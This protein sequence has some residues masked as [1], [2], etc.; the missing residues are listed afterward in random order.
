MKDAVS[1]DDF[2]RARRPHAEILNIFAKTVGDREFATT[3][4]ADELLT[5]DRASETEPVRCGESVRTAGAECAPAPANRFSL[6][7]RRTV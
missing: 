4:A 5:T 2:T 3:A 7:R 1:R 6:F